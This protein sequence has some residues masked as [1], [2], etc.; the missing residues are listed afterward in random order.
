MAD[1]PSGPGL[2]VMQSLLPLS[3]GYEQVIG[4]TRST[5]RGRRPL[6][7]AQGAAARSACIGAY[8][9]EDV[10]AASLEINLPQLSEKHVP[11][12]LSFAKP[13]LPS[14]IRSP[15]KMFPDFSRKHPRMSSGPVREHRHSGKSTGS[16][17]NGHGFTAP[18]FLEPQFYH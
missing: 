17:V 16:M 3:I 7:F 1:G 15:M 9:M 12:P 2:R 5:K 14:Q 4:Q 6:S 18:N 11:L 10:G 8:W 13:F